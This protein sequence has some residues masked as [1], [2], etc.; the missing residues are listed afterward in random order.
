MPLHTQTLHF[1]HEKLVFV[2][3]IFVDKMIVAI[4]NESCLTRLN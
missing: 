1:D 3:I 2:V 4:E